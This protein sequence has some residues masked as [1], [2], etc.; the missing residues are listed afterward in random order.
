MTQLKYFVLSGE[1][2]QYDESLPDRAH[3]QKVGAGNKFEIAIDLKSELCNNRNQN[4]IEKG[5]SDMKTA[6]TEVNKGHLAKIEAQIKEATVD[7][8][9]LIQRKCIVKDAADLEALEKVISEVTDRLAALITAQKIQQ[10]LDSDEILNESTDLIKGLGKK[11]KNQG[12]REVT[13]MTLR[14]GTVVIVTRYY[15]RKGF[16]RGIK[17]RRRPGLYPALYLLGIHDHCSPALGAEI[18]MMSVI[19]SSFEEARRELEERGLKIDVKTLRKITLRFARRAL[20]I[21]K[22]D[23]NIINVTLAG[24]RVVVSTDGGRMR[25]RQKKRGPKTQKGRNRYTTDWKEPKLSIIYTV[26]EKGEKERAFTPFIDGTLKGPNATFAL[27]RHYLS[28]LD[29]CEADKILFVADGA[30]WIWTRVPA[31]MTSLGLKPSQCYELIDFYH[32]VE[33]LGEVADLQ[34]GWKKAAKKRW[35][36]KNRSLLKKGKANK[37]INTIH[38]L[39]KGK[40][41]KNLRRELNYFIRN[42]KRLCYGKIKNAGLPIGSG[43]ME[44]AIRRVV[45]LRLKGAAMF[46]LRETAEAMLKLRSY[47]KA[48]RWNMLKTLAFS[49]ELAVA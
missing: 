22:T 38:E 36:N 19:L 23:K 27:I 37:V 9:E 5:D 32:A 49:R 48:G 35:I 3:S 18:S 25:I 6:N 12:P 13:V 16:L 8:S 44:S 24:S 30:R 21:Q 17:R 47:Y 31:L 11:M 20:A 43:A 4:T 34:K 7:I 28:K 46:W 39:C 15:S 41:I 33:H 40:R 29:I 42:R 14:G 26:N 45:N 1:I 2:S 10:S